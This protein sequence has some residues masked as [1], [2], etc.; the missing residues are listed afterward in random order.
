MKREHSSNGSNRIMTP[1]S[2]V[3][4]LSTKPAFLR[5]RAMLRGIVAG[6]AS[7][8]VGLPLLEIM[9]N[10]H[11]TALA[12]GEPLPVRLVTWF[13]GNGI[14]RARWIPGGVNT[15]VLGADY[16]IS[17]HLTPLAPVKQYVSVANYFKNLCAQR[18][19]HHEGMT[20]FNAYSFDQ[21][22]PNNSPECF[23][24]F[25][26]NAAGPTIDQVAADHIGK[27]TPVRSIQLGVSKRISGADFGTTMH[28]LS[29]KSSTEPLPPQRNP[30]LAFY[31]LFGNIPS[32]D[33]PAKPTRLSVLNAVR[34]QAKRLD[35]RLGA[36]DKA[37]M[38]AH[39]E[40]ISELE[41]KI[42]TMLPTCASPDEPTEENIDSGGVE[43]MQAV[44]RLMADLLTVAFSCDITRI[45]SVLFHEGA[46]DT[47]FPGT[48]DVTGHHNNSHMFYVDEQGVEQDGGGLAGF[49][50]GL[51]FTM[52][53][54]GYFLNKLMLTEDTPTTNILDNAAILIGSDCMDGWSHDFD[55]RQSLACLVAGRGGGRL[56]HPGIHIMQEGRNICDI[57]LTVLKAVVPEIESIGRLGQDPPATDTPVDELM[58]DET[59]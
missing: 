13:F 10:S 38:E 37:R 48:Q 28:T 57:S 50:T 2:R 43:P 56:A 29:H 51:T 1:P 45:A 5:R 25:Y 54:L 59:L 31:S 53:E 8:A 46:S 17:E 14:N 23:Q 30:K 35:A 18:I 40:A 27:L 7:V 19:T 58:S 20:L 55:E 32:A 34:E 36:K 3:T 47:V 49:N 42:D 21:S 26:S 22:C 9:L 44:S 33:D 12:G 41:G 39:L 16:P 52:T 15:P 4:N 11:G 24:G 6:G